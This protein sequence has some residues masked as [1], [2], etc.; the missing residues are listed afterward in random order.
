MKINFLKVKFSTISF[1]Y[2]PSIFR[3][4]IVCRCCG[5]WDLSPISL[6]LFFVLVIK[7]FD[8]QSG[9]WLPRWRLRFPNFR[10]ARHAHVAKFWPTACERKWCAWPLS[11]PLLSPHWLEIGNFRNS[12]LVP[13]STLLLVVSWE[14][15]KLQ[16]CLIHCILGFPHC[17]S[18]IYILINICIYSE[19][20]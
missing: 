11:F 10:A 18:L 5:S 4:W 9:T 19:T 17:S 20:I 8:F 12:F 14:R 13:K 2:I 16:Y 3:F 6:F 1:L 15:N 7:I